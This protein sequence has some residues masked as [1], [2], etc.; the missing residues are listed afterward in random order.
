M[1]ALVPTDITIQ[2]GWAYTKS[3]T[4]GPAGSTARAADARHWPRM[5]NIGHLMAGNMNR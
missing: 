5:A 1:T 2:F 3:E 4:M